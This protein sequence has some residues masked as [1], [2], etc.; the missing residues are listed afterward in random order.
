MKIWICGSQGMLG[1]HCLALLQKKQVP[2]VTSDVDTVDI[3]DL[4]QV[5]DFMQKHA[6]SHILNC[7]A[8][9]SVD[10]AESEACRAY[11]VNAKGP[12]Q[13]AVAA[14][15]SGA[16]LLHFSTDYVFDGKSSH[17]YKEADS[18]NPINAYGIS[19]RAGEIKILDTHTKSCI[20]RTSWLFGGNQAHFV[21][22][23]L[24]LL[25]ERDTLS[26]V[27][28]QIGSPTYCVDLAEA[29]YTLLLQE[30]TGFFHF[31]NQGTTSWFA[32]A[33][34]I[35]DQARALGW[36][37]RCQSLQPILTSQYP[38][39]AQRPS[40]S[41]LDTSKIAHI[42]KTPLRSW[43]EALADYLNGH[44]SMLPLHTKACVL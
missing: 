2:Y 3:T 5:L 17:P 9:T 4:S 19:K 39:P 25:Q 42:L 10:Q 22:K 28:D 41:C 13:L 14:K 21:E 29:A 36:H 40:Y 32:F 43:K 33:K 23:M 18:C 11:A 6:V 35:F 8:Y 44:E 34:E 16:Y 12:K 27:Q 26:V 7:A 37:F 31:S 30:R 20:I 1:Q 38:T 24:R 15:K